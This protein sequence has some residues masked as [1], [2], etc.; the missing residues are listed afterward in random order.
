MTKR[1]KKL[2]E[3]LL[4]T[5]VALWDLQPDT[6]KFVGGF[7]N[8]I[9]EGQ[10]NGK[11]WILRVGSH[12][13]REHTLAELDWVHYLSD[14]NIRVARPSLSRS[15]SL[16]ESLSYQE[17]ELQCAVF[18]KA[19]GTKV[20]MKNPLVWNADLWTKMGKLTGQMHSATQSYSVEG[21]RFRRVDFLE[22]PIIQ[23][24]DI[25]EKLNPL[26][27]ERFNEFMETKIFPLPSDRSCFGLIHSDFHAGNFFV[28]ENNDITLF[29][30]DD[31]CYKWFISDVAVAVYYS[32]LFGTPPDQQLQFAQN[33]FRAFWQGYSSEFNLSPEWAG[34]I[35]DFLR[36][37]DF[38][39]Y[40]AVNKI[41]DLNNLEAWQEKLLN[42]LEERIVNK[43]SPIDLT[44]EQWIALT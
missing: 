29:D 3:Q 15:D 19:Q 31:C 36:L 32:T 33:Y 22:D 14:N 39:L 34:F 43:T 25:E 18:E 38:T 23:P 35:P 40:F 11:D 37:R 7:E 41:V 13:S 9:Y 28:D 2:P 30:F 5:I 17:Y 10:K 6:I 20:D 8:L 26:V 16:V 4:N 44:S 12:Q 42:T 24:D 27:I 21:K 1:I